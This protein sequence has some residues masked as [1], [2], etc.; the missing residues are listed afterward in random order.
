MIAGCWFREYYWRSVKIKHSWQTNCREHV[1]IW[2]T[3]L[4]E[5]RSFEEQKQ[6]FNKLKFV[7][8]KNLELQN[9]GVATLSAREMRETNGGII[10]YILTAI[11]L[12]AFLNPRGSLKEFA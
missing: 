8:M 7:L 9:Y 5:L 2:I 4:T 11:V 3:N 1:Y 6:M 10:W 12:D